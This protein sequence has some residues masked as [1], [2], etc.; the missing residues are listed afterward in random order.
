MS[1]E[2]M[3]FRAYAVAD[4][5]TLNARSGAVLLRQRGSFGDVE[6]LAAGTPEQ[7]VAHEAA[8]AARV[9]DLPDS[10]LLPALVNAHAH[11]D[12]THIGPR[13]YDPSLGFIGWARMIM[14]ERARDDAAIDAS[15]RKGVERSLLG[16][17]AA[18]GDI[19]GALQPQPA[20]TLAA[21]PLLGVSFLECF[22]LGSRQQGAC[23]SAADRFGDLLRWMSR[24]GLRLGLQPH[25]PYSAGP[26]VRDWAIEMNRAYRAP[27]SM[28]LAETRPERELIMHAQGP[29]RAFL[30]SLG[31]WDESVAADFATGHGVV[32]SLI[33]HLRAAP[34]LLAH[35]N[36]C[37][38]VAIALLAN[39]SCS[40]AYCP[41]SSDYFQN[42]VDLGPHRYQDMLC[43][44]INVALGTDSIVNLPR[45][46]ASRLST[47][48]EMAFLRR[49]DHTDPPTL[50]RMA[51]TNGARALSLD[52]A[53]FTLASR[54]GAPRRIAGLIAV[55]L[56]PG[57]RGEAIETALR[58][59]RDI[60][61]LAPALAPPG[62]EP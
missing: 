60:S 41:R 35:V 39:T 10:I 62:G 18:V 8:S 23:E 58:L 22:G 19:G 4:A 3:L 26:R 52:P 51:T 31:L 16:G 28:H 29:T 47:F 44:G 12:L 38:D 42:H 53:L 15:V 13:P 43:A 59:G 56:A 50:L 9:I 40:I 11:L 24:T 2:C 20:R 32:R 17:V 33:E 6:L 34:W 21:S 25:S 54:D 37:D 5:D 14:R 27:L 45:E 48:D 30:E 36:D 46:Q 7:V 57:E 49:R 1:A 55:A 61:L